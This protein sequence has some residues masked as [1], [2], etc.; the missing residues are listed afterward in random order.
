[1]LYAEAANGEFNLDKK[2][3]THVKQDIEGK[4]TSE[5]GGSKRPGFGF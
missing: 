4:K 2:T 5:L 1:M 3:E